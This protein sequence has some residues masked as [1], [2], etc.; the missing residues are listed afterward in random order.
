MGDSNSIINPDDLL[1]NASYRVVAYQRLRDN[2]DWY[3]LLKI[4]RGTDTTD[5]RVLRVTSND[6]YIYD[7]IEKIISGKITVGRLT[8]SRCMHPVTNEV[9]VFCGGDASWINLP[10]ASSI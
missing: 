3:Y 1:I 6:H 7:K 2:C 8:I 4:A 9:K 5:E 10:G